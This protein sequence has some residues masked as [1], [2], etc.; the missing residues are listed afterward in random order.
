MAITQTDI[1]NNALILV[2][3]DRISS[4]DEDTKSAILLKAV[5]SLERDSS[6]RDHPWN[7]CKKRVTLSPNSTTP[8]FG[9]DYQYDLPS[10]Y[11][12]MIVIYP[13]GT[14]YRIE[15]GQILS[16]ETTL[17]TIY[18]YRNTDESSWGTDFCKAFAL[19]LAMTV[20]YALTQNA[21]LVEALEKKYKIF[22]AE[23]RSMN[24]MENPIKGLQADVFT[25]AR[26]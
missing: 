26:R 24:G 1:C 25:N 23:A 4:I 5:Y 14:D 16:D 15:N 3:A 21:S 22:L 20:G 7:S 12:K 13:F 6:L 2:G 8:D 10:D 18:I 17:D 9:Y 11:L 19:R